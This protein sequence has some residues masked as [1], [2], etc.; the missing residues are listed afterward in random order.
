MNCISLKSIVLDEYV[1]DFMSSRLCSRFSM[2]LDM[3]PSEATPRSVYVN[4]GIAFATTYF[5]MSSVM[6]SLAYA[7][8]FAYSRL[9]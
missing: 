6:S 5:A 1:C 8:L 2:L 9:G 4:R 3:P 7:T